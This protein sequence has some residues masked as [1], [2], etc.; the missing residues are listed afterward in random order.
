MTMNKN[1]VP[2]Y[3]G[4]FAQLGLDPRSE[5]QILAEKAR[6]RYEA[7][8]ADATARGETHAGAT[9]LRRGGASLASFIN[10]K[11]NP[12]KLTPDQQ[13]MVDAQQYAKEAVDLMNAAGEF[14]NE[15]GKVDAIKLGEERMMKIAEYLLS[16][17][18]PRGTDLA[19]Q[20]DNV[21]RKRA[22]DQAELKKLGIDIEQAEL[23]IIKTGQD[24]EH[25]DLKM[26]DL[27]RQIIHST[28]SDERERYLARRG[29]MSPIYMRG[30]NDPNSSRMAFIQDNGDAMYQND[31]GQYVNVP[32]GEYTITRPDDPNAGGGGKDPYV[33]TPTEQG[34]L[35][36]QQRSIMQQLR[37]SNIMLDAM[38]TALAETGTLDMMDGSGKF[39][40]ATTHLANN[41]NAVFR[42]GQKWVGITDGD[43]ND[44]NSKSIGTIDGSI[45]S[46]MSYVKNN[47]K[48]MDEFIPVP[49][50]IEKGTVQAMRYQAAIVQ[51][52]YAKARSNEPGA[53]QLSDNDFKNAIKQIGANATSPEQ[54][55]QVMLDNVATAHE[56]FNIWLKQIG[57]EHANSIIEKP[58]MDEYYRELEKFDKNWA[59]A[60]GTVTEPEGEVRERAEEKGYKGKGTADD[61]IVITR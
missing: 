37:L 33:P 52:A 39:Q 42:Q 55:R 36:A 40:T 30:S 6:Q 1:Q 50:G 59:K 57:P 44:P 60:W 29:E 18:D 15:D 20:V 22:H 3:L 43:P 25:T 34:N 23:D 32:L 54:L 27:R 28:W 45:A 5:E 53:R 24:M 51:L 9:A 26:Q 58:A 7:A 61:P 49:E 48:W 13:N 35:R 47:V 19:V 41:V 46:S 21:R 12:P 56:D 16:K 11:I 14:T 10:N 4:M 17:G 8:K 38:T 31:Q 2:D